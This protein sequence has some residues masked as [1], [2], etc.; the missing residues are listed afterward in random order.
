MVQKPLMEKYA[1]SA[2]GSIFQES[3]FLAKHCNAFHAATYIVA[4][5]HEALAQSLAAVLASNWWTTL[6]NR[7]TF[8]PLLIQTDSKIQTAVG[9]GEV[10]LVVVFFRAVASS[11][12]SGLK[13]R[14]NTLQRIPDIFVSVPCS[15]HTGWTLCSCS[16]IDL[17]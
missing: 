8:V 3:S 15:S 16:G 6:E 12:P 11:L 17:H 2:S 10:I 7:K 1:G 5:Q 9:G 13:G 4:P 14:V